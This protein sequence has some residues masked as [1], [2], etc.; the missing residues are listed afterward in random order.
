MRTHVLAEV[1][2]A[3][4]ICHVSKSKMLNDICEAALRYILSGDSLLLTE[5]RSDLQN[6]SRR[7]F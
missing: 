2:R 3:S 5:I 1:E 4:K 6:G 7:T